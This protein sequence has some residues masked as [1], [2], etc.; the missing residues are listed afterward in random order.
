[1][2]D[3][4]IDDAYKFSVSDVEARNAEF[5]EV[6]PKI[7][8]LAKT[9]VVR[10]T[11]K[12][13]SGG[14]VDETRQM[15]VKLLVSRSLMNSGRISRFDA[16]TS[17]GEVLGQKYVYPVVGENPDSRAKDA[18]YERLKIERIKRE[19]EEA[20]EGGRGEWRKEE[21]STLPKQR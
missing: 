5:I 20:S 12:K 15:L 10:D 13:T 7:Y 4:F 11:A 1:M 8:E 16:E 18:A 21:S 3:N 2:F 17:F 14:A 6:H 9:A 19:K